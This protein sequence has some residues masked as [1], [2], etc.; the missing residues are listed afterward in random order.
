LIEINNLSRQ[1]SKSSQNIVSM[2]VIQIDSV[3][4]ASSIRKS[5]ENEF[6]SESDSFSSSASELLSDSASSTSSAELGETKEN[7]F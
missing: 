7:L 4:Q 3:S 5:P 1:S 2:P 6:T